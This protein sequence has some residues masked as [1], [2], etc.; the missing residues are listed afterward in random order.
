MPFSKSSLQFLIDLKHN[1]NRQW[2]N[3]N[4]DRYVEANND[5]K[6]FVEALVSEMNKVDDIERHKLFR[7][8]R[9][10]RF[11]KDKTPYNHHFSVSMTRSKP[12]LRGGYFL[13]IRPGESGIA[14]GFWQPNAQD[15]LLIRK[16]IEADPGRYVKAVNAKSVVANFD[17]FIGD[18]VKTAPKG[19]SK[20]HPQIEH[21]RNRS[22]LFSNDFSDEEVVSDDFLGEVVNRFKN[23]RP[24]FDYMSDILSHNL[25][26]EPLY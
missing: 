10:V 26:G 2:F 12:Y 7:I 4:K 15:L 16:N 3:E 25:N 23:I 24:F 6:Q 21:I 14:S 22:F 9:D 8:Y 13:R 20:D 17:T 5:F 18:P 19:F 1:N 11:S